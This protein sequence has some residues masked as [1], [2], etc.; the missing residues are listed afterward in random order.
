ML[1][2]TT[3]NVY[4][5]LDEYL[6]KN[7]G[8]IKEK[9]GRKIILYASDEKE[10]ATYINLIKSQGMEA[11]IFNSLIDMH[12]IQFLEMKD[13][14]ISF[15][16]IDS[17]THD[18][19]TEENKESKIVDEQNKTSDDKLKDIFE[20]NLKEDNK[21]L[22]IEIKP[23][24]DQSISAM[25]VLSEFMRRFKE[26]NM[27]QFKDENMN[28]F[29]DHTLIVNSNNSSVKDLLALSENSENDEKIKL[30]V[31]HIY[32]L[33][34]LSQNNLKGDRLIKFINRSNELLKHI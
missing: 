26:M 31:N 20:K 16:R 14:K 13:Q 19:L 2:K 4:K 11:L 22:K 34:L 5:T 3:D 18:S 21:N 12:F 33:A 7:K 32:D 9:D 24:K 1:Y 23:L 15:S 10:Q 27:F 29:G 30:T 28:S 17:D 6:E 8:I 25:I